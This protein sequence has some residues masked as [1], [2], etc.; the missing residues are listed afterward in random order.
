MIPK[1]K[2]G[3]YRIRIYLLPLTD[4]NS[5]VLSLEECPRKA[6][7][8]AEGGSPGGQCGLSRGGCHGRSRDSKDI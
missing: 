3:S 1:K 6:C 7:I 4:T 8:G 5:S 2:S